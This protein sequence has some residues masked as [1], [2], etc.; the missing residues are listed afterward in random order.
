VAPGHDVGACQVVPSG[1]RWKPADREETPVGL[2]D[3]NVSATIPA[4]DM[5]RARSYYAD[6]LGLKPA[7]ER[8]EG[9]RYR[10][11]TGEF[12]LFPSSGKASGAHTQ[13]GWDVDDLEATMAELR[14]NGVVFEE[15]DQPGFKSVNGIVEIE[16][17]RG[18][19]FKDSEGNLLALGE[20]I[21]S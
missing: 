19:W 4:Q 18:A 9:L 20:R 1:F 8:P 7:E 11:G 16:G 3:S 12:L 2:A 14:A 13:V 15:Y 17:E 6:K 5:D 21:D 10:C